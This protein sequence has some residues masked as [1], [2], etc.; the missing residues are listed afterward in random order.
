MLYHANSDGKTTNPSVIT[1]LMTF[2][3][4]PEKS[5]RAINSTLDTPPAAFRLARNP[6]FKALGSPSSSSPDPASFPRGFQ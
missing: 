5:L 3:N 1:T 4:N 2:L 6:A